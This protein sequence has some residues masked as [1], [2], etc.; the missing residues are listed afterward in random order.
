MCVRA[1]VRA[2]VY[3]AKG[4]ERC[5]Q[6]NSCVYIHNIHTH[7]NIYIQGVDDHGDE[8]VCIYTHIN[9]YLQGVDDQ[10]DTFSLPHRSGDQQKRKGHAQRRK[11]GQVGRQ[12]MGLPSCW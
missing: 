2:C 10:G 4:K 12:K 7:Q 1:C 11:R 9:T 3:V 6:E 8:Y 5:Y